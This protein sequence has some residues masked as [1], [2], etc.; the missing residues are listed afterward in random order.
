MQFSF[1]QMLFH[2]APLLRSESSYRPVKVAFDTNQLNL[3]SFSSYCG[4]QAYLLLF[5]C[6]TS[7]CCAFILL[8]SV[9][10]VLQ[11]AHISHPSCCYPDRWMANV[12]PSLCQVL[13]LTLSP[14]TWYYFIVNFHIVLIISLSLMLLPI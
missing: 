14:A 7:I 6:I 11:V 5:R 3:Y 1:E 2:F 13:V 12:F 8:N 10:F 4:L 9:L